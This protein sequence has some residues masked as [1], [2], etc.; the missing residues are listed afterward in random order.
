MVGRALSPGE[1]GT[2]IG[3]GSRGLVSLIGA[4]PGDPELLTVKAARRIAEAD[5]IVHDRL[6]GEEILAGV[7]TGVPRFDVGK[8]PGRSGCRQEEI[9]AL[10]VRLGR[11]GRRV[12]RL[13]GGDPFI[14]GR[15][16]EEVIA[17]RA[18]GVAVEVIPGV[19]SALAAPAA[20]GIPVTHRGL[21]LS[22]TIATG[23]ARAEAAG[24]DHDWSALARQRGTLVFL[25]AVENLELIVSSL[26]AHGRAGDEPAAIVQSATRPTQRVVAGPL[27]RIVEIGRTACVAPPAVLVVGPTVEALTLGPP[28]PAETAPGSAFPRRVTNPKHVASIS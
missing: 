16:G 23:H 21:A 2:L 1:A 28:V 4:G 6:V 8:G 27:G 14:F 17:L 24:L 9:N 25:M 3:E 26:L 15:G 19:S 11:E 20:A 5:A 18:A 7:A 10:L 13:K 22:V 12:A